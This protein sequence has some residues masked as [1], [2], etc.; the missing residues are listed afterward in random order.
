VA[1]VIKH[2]AVGVRDPADW[3]AL[4]DMLDDGWE[5]YWSDTEHET[6]LFILRREEDKSGG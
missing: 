5:I 2:K 1:T 3:K 6:W 4:T